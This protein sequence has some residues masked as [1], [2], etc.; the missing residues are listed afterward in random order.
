MKF[1]Y[2]LLA[3]FGLFAPKFAGPDAFD[4]RLQ[5]IGNRERYRQ[6]RPILF[7]Q[8]PRLMEV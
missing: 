2:A 6:A 8:L 3:R 5:R 1:G 4:L 7:R